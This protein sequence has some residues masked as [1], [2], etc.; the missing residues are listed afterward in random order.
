MAA[1]LDLERSDV[2]E[3]FCSGECVGE[4]GGSVGSGSGVSTADL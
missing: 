1:D 2:D 4:L 3:G